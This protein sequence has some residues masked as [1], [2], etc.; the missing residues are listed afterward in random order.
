LD[1]LGRLL[2]G[3]MK[4]QS[5]GGVTRSNIENSAIRNPQSEIV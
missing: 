2:G 4:K 5:S 3:L 1:E